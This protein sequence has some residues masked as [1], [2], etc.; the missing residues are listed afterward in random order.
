MK[1]NVLARAVACVTGLAAAA[2]SSS[3]QQLTWAQESQTF[4][5]W[6]AVHEIVGQTSTATIAGGGDPIY[7]A[8]KP[9]Y[10]GAV[11]LLMNYG[12]A[13]NF[14]CSG[15]LIGSFTVL[16]AAHCVS[17]A[18]RGAPLSTTAFFY[19]G[20]DDPSLYAAGSGA[21]QIAVSSTFVHPLYT[22]TVIDQN[23]IAVLNLAQAAPA[24]API[25]GLSSLT[26][27]TGVDHIIA[28]Y[29]VRSDTG[30]SVGSNLGSGRLRYAGNRFDFR[31]G[32]ADFEG[33]WT[34]AFPAVADHV[35]ISDFDNGTAFRDGS[36]NVAI[37]EGPNAPAVFGKPV[38]T[39]DK[40]CNTGIRDANNSIAFEGIGGG[41]D[42]GAGYYVEGKI[43]AVHSFALWYRD[44][45]STNRFGQLKGAVPVYQ[46]I[47]FI[48]AS[49]VPEPSTWAMA[50]AGFA[51]IGG[52]VRRRRAARAA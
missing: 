28:G 25:L 9:Q 20:A 43:A 29:G 38:F 15:S 1:L 3:A 11:G 32:D 13:G 8:P 37:F 35:W 22:K 34:G 12:A 18:T 44:D 52:A 41:G 21:T 24:F 49:M 5:G 48:R 19:A 7:I 23:D 45:E 40:Y 6:T 50:I 36:C 16:T 27:L 10:S 4:N 17:S 14:V 30:G 33:Y 51:L 42:S 2:G 31:F 39:S 46:H 26:D 47:D